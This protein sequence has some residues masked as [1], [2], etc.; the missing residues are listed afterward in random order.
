MP[1]VGE[2][3][4]LWGVEDRVRDWL[5]SRGI[6]CL[7]FSASTNQ[8][9]IILVGDLQAAAVNPMIGDWQEL[10]RRAALGSVVVFLAPVA[11]RRDDNPVGWLPLPI[12]HKGRIY[13]FNDWLYHKEC[14]AR[15][16]PIF[17]GLAE[18]GIMDWDYYGPL[19]SRTMFDGQNAPADTMAAAFAV[20]YPCP[21]GAAS[22]LVAGSYRFGAGLFVLNTL[23]ILENVDNHPAADRMLLN[24]IRYAAGETV[25]PPAALPA[26]FAATLSAIGY[27]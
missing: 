10:A 26:D 13:E 11:L 18:A 19:I 16:H 17:E 20:G 5:R 7:S 4:T 25:A 1:H 23:K 8:N 24:I 6:A 2:P 15:A 3:V 27:I 21:G 22:G 9:Q 12:E 14:V